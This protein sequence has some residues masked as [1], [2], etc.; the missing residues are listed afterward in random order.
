MA[1]LA[2]SL[3]GRGEELAAFERALGEA[4]AGASRVVAL[5]GEP[6]IGKSRLAG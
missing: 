1:E 3:V 6:G 4:G 2:S 5:R